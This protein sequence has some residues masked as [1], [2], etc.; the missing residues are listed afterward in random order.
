MNVSFKNLPID[1]LR[2]FVTVTELNNVSR[3]GEMLGRSQPAISLQ[4][5]R[6]ESIINQNLFK[7][8]QGHRFELTLSGQ[9]LF[10]YAQ[11]MLVL[12][13]EAVNYFAKPTIRDSIRL[14]I[15]NEFASTLLPKIIGRFAKIYPGVRLEVTSDLSNNLAPKFLDKQFDLLLSLSDDENLISPHSR[16]IKQDKLVWVSKQNTEAHLKKTIPLVVAPEGCLYRRRILQRLSRANQPW[17]IVY[18]IPGL[19]GI[20][21]AIAEGLGVTA[22]AKST[23]PESLDIIPE[24]EQFPDLGEV[25]ISLIREVDSRSEAIDLLAEYIKTSLL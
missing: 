3:A 5:K 15:P 18:T 19:T 8:T 1:L 14:G 13:D 11:R 23:M 17:S 2:T 21:A 9:V 16:I 22:L 6:L 12:N 20:Q 4:M 25:T 10:D 24:S 7:R